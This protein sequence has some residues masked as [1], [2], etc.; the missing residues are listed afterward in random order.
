MRL[1]FPLSWL[2]VVVFFA[3]AYPGIPVALAPTANAQL[4]TA[5]KTA[6]PNAR[7]A[8]FPP[9]LVN[10]SASP[11]NPVFTAEGAGHWDVK[12]RERGWILRDGD[13][14]RL[15]FTGY[16]GTREGIKLPGYATSHDGIHWKQW[17]KN[18]IYRDHW[19]EDMSVV[20]RGGTYYMF[21]E[22]AH[23][24]HAEMLTSKNG[25]EWNWQ[26]ELDVRL[27]D[28]KHPA[29]K[30]CGT[31]TVCVD[32]DKW[33]LFYEYLDRGAWLATTKD[34]MSRV[35]TNVQ[36]GPVLRPGPGQ[37]D[38]D[39]IAIDQIIKYRGIYYALYHG[40]GSGTAIPRT[41]NTD[42]ARSTDLIHWRKYASNPIVDDNKSSGIVVPSA[43]GAASQQGFRL[44]TM[45]DRVDLFEPDAR[46][47]RP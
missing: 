4:S 1:R 12:I 40:S 37:Y 2:T 33:Y 46:R 10:W 26:G 43:G 42:I 16:D 41:W 11:G 15:W 7:G 38:K 24:N 20:R 31:P 22:G 28:G 14:Y 19:V 5:T 30:P 8:E 34:P 6:I 17:A 21:A 29:P 35:W 44:Y 27:A 25:I 47:Q 9:E 45:H 3:L 18:P 23:Q 13:T 32:D 36:N 39:L